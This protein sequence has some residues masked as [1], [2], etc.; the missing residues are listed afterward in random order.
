[1]GLNGRCVGHV[2]CCRAASLPQTFKRPALE[3]PG[4]EQLPHRE[5][6]QRPTGSQSRRVTHP[7]PVS[8]ATEI[9]EIK[10]GRERKSDTSSEEEEYL[11]QGGSLGFGRD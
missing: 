7:S 2:K 6:P 1:M 10:A 5:L 9:L 3:T 4:R 11:D 8:P